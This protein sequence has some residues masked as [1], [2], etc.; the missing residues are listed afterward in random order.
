VPTCKSYLFCV[1]LYCHFL[2]LLFYHIFPHLLINTKSFRKMTIE[3]KVYGLI[4]CTNFSEILLNLGR[5]K[6]DII[7][8][9]F[10]D[11]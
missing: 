9:V 8:T 11:R 2:P 5:I 1:V 6:Q 7:I 4:C 3:Y 10:F